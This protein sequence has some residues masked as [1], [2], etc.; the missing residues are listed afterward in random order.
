[1]LLCLRYLTINY[2]GWRG[3]ELGRI[4]GK[5]QLKNGGSMGIEMKWLA[6]NRNMK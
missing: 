4:G 5:W 3:E 2:N 6:N 1:M